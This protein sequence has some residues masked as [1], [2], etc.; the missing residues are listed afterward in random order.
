MKKKKIIKTY[1]TKYNYYKQPKNI[2][3]V[4]EKRYNIMISIIIMVMVLLLINLF[5]V[6]VINKQVYV[7]KLT[8]LNQNIIYG[9]TAPR[10]RIYDCNG[11][12]IVDNKAIKVIYYKKES[13][14]TTKDEVA[15]AYK[16]GSLIDLDFTKLND[17]NL[18]NFWLINNEDLGNK[19]VTADEW[20]QYEERK[21]TSDRIKKL[22]LDR[23]TDLELGEYNDVD[24]E[25]A[26]IYFLMNKGYSYDEKIIK[27][28]YISDKEYAKVSE[29]I[30][31]LKGV[32]TRLDWERDYL[33]GDAFR[34]ILGSVSSTES[35]IPLELKDYYLSKGY[36]LDDQVG[37]SYLEYT[38]DHY[39]K[40]I[41]NKYEVLKDGSYRLIEEGKRGNDIVLTI[42]MELQLA[43]EKIII[44]ELLSAKKEPNTEYYNRSFVIISN[45]KTGEILAMA[46]KQIVRKDNDYEV[47][48]YTPGV[49]TS[50][51][52]AG[53]VI[54]GAS[55]IVGYNTGALKIGE[56]RD[57]ACIKIQNTPIKC[58][59]MYLG[60][61]NDLTA[62][63]QSSNT[64]QFHTAIKVGKGN[65]Q[66]NRPLVINKDAFKI[67][68]DTF[69]EFGLGIKT[70]IDLP[71]ESLGYK[72]NNTLPGYILDFSIGQYDTY[73]PIQLSQY[74]GTIA[75]NGYRMQPYLL[76]SVYQPSDGSLSNLL[77]ETKP[78]VLNKINT[79]DEY[80]KR[81]QLGFKTVL[82]PY[83]TGYYY[84]DPAFNPAGKTGTS[85]SFIDTNNDGVV[86]TET[87]TH[88]F[89]A[90]APYDN[91]S[92]TFTIVSPDI[93]H[94]NTGS[95][96]Q[97][98]VNSRLAYQVSKKYF[99]FY[100]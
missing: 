87:I 44:A 61:V 74:I 6:Q 65:Y 31:V 33:Y 57:D 63:T 40:G 69:S 67:Y 43:I 19:K 59:W 5:Y 93:S 13:K 3:D 26:Y 20:Q 85:Q 29:N 46:G 45:P 41:K 60:S 9:D 28:D 92:V 86:D 66:Y 21:L 30:D 10:G 7:T 97:S 2:K 52:V 32:N 100:K 8:Q 72:G 4:I 16:L 17:Q 95:Y 48:D 15:L 38:Y 14:V 64:F 84:V 1:N 99:Q 73:T 35:G 96:Y 81:V 53:S 18:R 27:K 76:K 89:V 82:E 34:T 37:T 75:N 68:R 51:V 49:I 25:A 80:L 83:G 22:K 88:N 79:K 78:N 39:L 58:S 50:P 94:R 24:K 23:I 77:Y 12:L 90:Y 98:N 91:P 71:V 36:S 54:K 70:G 62:L 47:Y 11:R 56:V 42:D 55:H